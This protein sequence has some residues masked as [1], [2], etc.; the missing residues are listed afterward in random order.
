[1]SEDTSSVKVAVRVRPLVDSEKQKGSR[2]IIEV[3]DSQ[4]VV[5]NPFTEKSFTFNYA[6][7]STTNQDVFYERV[8]IH[9]LEIYSR[10]LMLQFWHMGRQDREK[11]I[12]W[13]LLITNSRMPV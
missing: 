8:S 4:V 9:L 2:N 5:R 13:V 12:Q 6:F 7:D 10:A 1:M 11:H 3:I